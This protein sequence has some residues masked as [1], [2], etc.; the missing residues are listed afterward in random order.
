MRAWS[1]WGEKRDKEAEKEE[2]GKGEEKK[3]EAAKEVPAAAPTA[4]ARAA[5]VA[6]A[7]STKDAV[8]GYMVSRDAMNGTAISGDFGA[9]VAAIVANRK[10]VGELRVI[11]KPPPKV[12]QRA[13]SERPA[14]R[15]I[16]EQRR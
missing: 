16:T 5:P 9:M 14:K 8:D 13:L 3:E 2:K 7:M 10:G 1:R 11:S 15:P 4:T 12:R 6:P